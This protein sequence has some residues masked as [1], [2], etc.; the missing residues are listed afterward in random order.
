[1]P[2]TQIA[3]PNCR[4]PAVAELEPLIDVGADPQA[5]QRLLSGQANVVQCQSCGYTGMLATPIVYHD[6]EKELLLTF[7]PPEMGMKLQDQE[8][9]LGPLIKKAVDALPM[10]KRK[11]YLFRPQ[12]ILTFQG[13]IERILEADGITREMI[14]AQ[15]KKMQLL[16][17]LANVTT[18]DVLAEIVKQ[19]GKLMDAEF[20]NILSRVIENSM[21]SGDRNSAQALMA[22]QQKLL[23][24]TE[25]GRQVQAQSQEVQAAMKSL[26]DL[27]R[28]LTREKLL[29]LVIEAPTPIRVE[30]LASMARPAMDYAFFQLLSEKIDQ[31]A[32]DEKQKLSALRERLLALTREVDLQMEARAAQSKQLLEAILAEKDIEAAMMQAIQAQAVDDFF[33]QAFTTAQEAARKSANLDL[34]AKLGKIQKVI[35]EASAPPPELQFVQELL[36][37]EDDAAMKAMLEANREIITPEFLEMMG[38]LMSQPQAAEDPELGQRLQALYGMVVRISMESSLAG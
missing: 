38:A 16:Q 37:T 13:L 31:A 3:C 22:L 17:R 33:M 21:M 20:F 14:Q 1:M 24:L 11:A 28:D 27:G 2:R 35:E 4:Q 26:Q 32:G 19:E 8:R 10:E 34:L 18:E 12:S 9:V 36:E 15:Q 7:S 30:A 6:P 29:D 23:P 25:Y 5:K